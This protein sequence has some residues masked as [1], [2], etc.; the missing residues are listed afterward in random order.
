MLQFD[1]KYSTSIHLLKYKN[2]TPNYSKNKN[3]FSNMRYSNKE[4]KKTDLQVNELLRD[5]QE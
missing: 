1:T 3:T 5:G 2:P 4:T